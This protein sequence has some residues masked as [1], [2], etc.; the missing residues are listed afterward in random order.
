MTNHLF[1]SIVFLVMNV[2][3]FAQ[4][5]FIGTYYG[6]INGDNAELVLQSAGTNALQGTMK[7]SQQNYAVSATTSGNKLT[8]KAVENQLGIIFILDGTLDNNQLSTTMTVE[9]LG[10][11]QTIYIDFMKQG[12][13]STMPTVAK[14]EKITLPDNAQHNSSLVGVWSKEE[15]YNSGFGDNYMGGSFSQSLV[16]YAD[17]SAADGGS[18]AGISGSNYSGNSQSG[19][20][21]LPNIMWYNIGNQLYLMAN[22]NGK[23]ET[24]HLGRYFIERNKLLITGANGNEILLTKQ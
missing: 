8:G 9:V 3:L 16:F 1:I 21:A 20:Q 10:N 17:G 13:A 2:P 5:E 14:N 7:D 19:V 24:I 22:Q 18:S 11:T 15:Y 23:T 4:T 12:S 6:Q